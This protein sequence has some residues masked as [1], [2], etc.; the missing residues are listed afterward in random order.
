MAASKRPSDPPTSPAA[1][2]A[3]LDG[4][5]RG[6][7]QLSADASAEAR[8]ILGGLA[9]AAVAHEVRNT[10]TP[11]RARLELALLSLEDAVL[12]E[13]SIRQALDSI[14]RASRVTDAMLGAIRGRIATN[15]GIRVID[16]AREAVMSVT[17]QGVLIRIEANPVDIAAVCPSVLEQILVNLLNNALAVQ[18]NGSVFI[19]SFNSTAGSVG[20]E[21]EDA[22]PGMSEE[23]LA[24]AMR[25]ES[26]RGGL[27]LII[28]RHLA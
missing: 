20:V 4:I 15:L 8:S 1:I 2:E 14:A 9:A 5:D 22:G 12:V 26:A 13:R 23:A 18:K 25:G 16:A 17:P 21:V 10:L 27:G 7:G 11:A 19:R 28:C 6:F 24:T 3:A